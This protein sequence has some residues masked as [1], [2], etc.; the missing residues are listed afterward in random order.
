MRRRRKA[1]DRRRRRRSV[2]GGGGCWRDSHVG[3]VFHCWLSV[4]RERRRGERK[5]ELE[6]TT[7]GEQRSVT[8]LR[9]NLL[10]ERTQ[11]RSQLAREKSV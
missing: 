3:W 8:N 1:A 7:R 5:G 6:K 10:L 9:E 11:W 2:G 4:L